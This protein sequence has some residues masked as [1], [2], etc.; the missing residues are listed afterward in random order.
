MKL[1]RIMLNGESGTPNTEVVLKLA[2]L[3]N[4]SDI[5][6]DL[7]IVNVA[8]SLLISVPGVLSLIF[9]NYFVT[10]AA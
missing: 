3:G 9:T 7:E 8:F 2:I 6:Q 5:I 4:I 1:R 10:V